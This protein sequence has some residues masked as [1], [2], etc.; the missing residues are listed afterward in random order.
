MGE[1]FD[2]APPFGF[3]TSYGDPGL[4]EAVRNGRCQEFSEFAWDEI[5]D[6]E[7]PATFTNSKLP[8]EQ[9]SHESEMLNWYQELI[10]LR[11]KFVIGG[12][13][14]CRVRVKGDILAME[15]PREQPVIRV[16]VNFR[17]KDLPAGLPGFQKA[18]LA[19]DE[20][21]AVAVYRAL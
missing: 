2:Q 7:D 12:D 1:E 21:C 18:L 17:G 4:K 9:L 20:G 14:T 10:A 13:R 11:K 5:P 15:V 16:E 19:A 3:F 6:P 8:W